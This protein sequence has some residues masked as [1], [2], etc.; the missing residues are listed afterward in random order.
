MIRDIHGEVHQ[1]EVEVFWEMC[2]VKN[3]LIDQRAINKA[4]RRVNQSEG[5]V[6]KGLRPI[7]GN[8]NGQHCEVVG[9]V[10]DEFC[11]VSGGI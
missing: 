1:I 4:D 6:V 2:I 3:R 9:A 8:V 10:Q 5:E 7:C 11:R